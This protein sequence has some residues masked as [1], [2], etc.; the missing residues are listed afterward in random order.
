M[1]TK[2]VANQWMKEHGTIWRSTQLIS[3]GKYEDGL[4]RELRPALKFFAVMKID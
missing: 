4:G 1:S 2:H 3:P